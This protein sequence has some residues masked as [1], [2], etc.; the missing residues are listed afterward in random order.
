VP[1]KPDNNI[2]GRPP[3]LPVSEQPEKAPEEEGIFGKI[4]GLFSGGKCK[5]SK[6]SKKSKKSKRTKKSKKSKK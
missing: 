4:K 3:Q 2:P 6:R 5:R 1:D